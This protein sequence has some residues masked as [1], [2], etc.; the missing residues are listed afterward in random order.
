L[1]K[2]DEDGIAFT[3]ISQEKEVGYISEHC[4]S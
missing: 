4:L 3:L 1:G 2:E